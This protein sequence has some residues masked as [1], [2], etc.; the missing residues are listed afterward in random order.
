MLHMD[1]YICDDRQDVLKVAEEINRMTDE[2]FD[3]Y[4]EKLKS[5]EFS[6]EQHSSKCECKER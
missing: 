2:E 5:E 3:A 6:R 4:C 1:E